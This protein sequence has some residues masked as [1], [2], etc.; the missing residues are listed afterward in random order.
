MAG[1]GLI[2]SIAHQQQQR[3]SSNQRSANALT[4]EML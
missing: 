2:I 4:S 3:I 1:S